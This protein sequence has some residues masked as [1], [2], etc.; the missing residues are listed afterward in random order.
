MHATEIAT[1]EI[2][3]FTDLRIRGSGMRSDG[4]VRNILE[5]AIAVKYLD[6]P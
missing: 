1:Y 4:L 6:S 5:G 3:D 2:W